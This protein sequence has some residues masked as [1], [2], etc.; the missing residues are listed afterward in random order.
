ML[1]GGFIGQMHD[2]MKKNRE[3][4]RAALG[5]SKR[6]PFD[7]GE[8]PITYKAIPEDKKKLSKEEKAILIERFRRENKKEGIKRI[9]ILTLILLGLS[10]LL[11]GL[12]VLLQF[13]FG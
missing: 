4:V 8:Y 9:V 10:L 11:L 3:M 6:K 7:N 13:M 2:T 5:K 1:G 12:P